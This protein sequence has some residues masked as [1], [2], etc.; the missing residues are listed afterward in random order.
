MKLNSN[1]RPYVGIAI[2]IIL[3]I[4][5]FCLGAMWQCSRTPEPI[6]KEKTVT[7]VQRDTITQ[8]RERTITV[9]KPVPITSTITR[10][11]RDTLLTTQILHDT[12][13]VYTPVVADIPIT[14]SVYSGE[15]TLSDSVQ[16][17]YQA[18]VSG[19]KPSLDSLSFRVTYPE[20]Q[21]FTNTTTVTT[22]TKKKHFG[23]GPAF[24]V[25]Y[26]LTSKKFDAYVGL[27]VTYSF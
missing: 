21:V 9:T 17:E 14:S 7:T 11:E 23:I 4:T 20:R 5:L 6:E 3:T 18:A 19:Y 15:K 1:L 26:G 16:V 13:T 25:G 8:W 10:V 27:S 22:N 24:G 12:D 2:G